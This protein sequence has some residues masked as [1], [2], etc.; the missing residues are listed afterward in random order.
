MMSGL[1]RLRQLWMIAWPKGESSKCI[2]YM[3]QEQSGQS[4]E[5]QF[6]DLG[7]ANQVIQHRL[8]LLEARTWTPKKSSNKV[9]GDFPNSE[10]RVDL[11]ELRYIALTAVSTN[12]S[13]ASS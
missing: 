8:L 2:L 12:R 3:S 11:A 5:A 6:Q 7:R 9:R 4:T 10:G 13:R 1:I